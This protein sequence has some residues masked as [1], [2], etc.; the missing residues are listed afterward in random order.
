MKLMRRKIID[1]RKKIKLQHLNTAI[2]LFRD[3]GIIRN[4]LTETSTS[5]IANI[6]EE[7]KPFYL[8]SK[9]TVTLSH[10]TVTEAY[11]I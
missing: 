9:H 5:S 11:Y 1:L 4:T 10:H 2:L 3:F 7:I 8:N 6:T